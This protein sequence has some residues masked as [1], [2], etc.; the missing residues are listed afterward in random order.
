M[1]NKDFLEIRGLTWKLEIESPLGIMELWDLITQKIL[2]WAKMWWLEKAI[3]EEVPAIYVKN[4]LG[5]MIILQWYP[6][7]VDEGRYFISFQWELILKEKSSAWVNISRYLE[8][9]FIKELESNEIKIL[10]VK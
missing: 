9:L 7:G 10:N 3:Y 4:F 2:W 6:I 8:E 5:M 1:L